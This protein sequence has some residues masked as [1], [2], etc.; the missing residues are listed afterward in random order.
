VAIPQ[1]A[2]ADLGESVT[3]RRVMKTSATIQS[4]DQSHRNIELVDADGDIIKLQVPESIKSFD[5]LN[6]GDKIDVTYRQ[7]LAVRLQQPGEGGGG[8]IQEK[9]TEER[10]G[11]NVMLGRQV[12]ASAEIVGV[13]T[14]RHVLRLKGP[15]GKVHKIHVEDTELQQKMSKLKTGEHLKVTYNEAVATMIVPAPK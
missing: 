9:L 4:I 11:G 8:G 7:A 5:R 1:I 2:Q 3:A 12:M 6:K 15:D 10:S 14:A 13:D